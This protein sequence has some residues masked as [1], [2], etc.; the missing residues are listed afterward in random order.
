MG[1]GGF[2]NGNFPKAAAWNFSM[3][4]LEKGYGIILVT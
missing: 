1:A 2:L 3:N 4:N